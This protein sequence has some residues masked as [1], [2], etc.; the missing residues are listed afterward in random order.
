[1]M[2]RQKEEGLKVSLTN[3]IQDWLYQDS[4]DIPCWVGDSIA[5]IMATAAL[6]VLRGMNDAQDYLR[7]QDMLHDGAD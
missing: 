7:A 2:N 4:T 6:A 3:A 5:E 1:M